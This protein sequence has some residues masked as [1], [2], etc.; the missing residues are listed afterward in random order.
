MGA[1][2]VVIATAIGLALPL[3]LAIPAVALC[4]RAL[5]DGGEFEAEIK[6]PSVA[7]R[8]RAAGGAVHSA[9]AD[10]SDSPVVSQNVDAGNQRRQPEW[11][12]RQGPGK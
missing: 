4:R 8:M 3:T 2:A 7:I 12:A 5:R 1:D 10:S 6:G 11:A 9:A